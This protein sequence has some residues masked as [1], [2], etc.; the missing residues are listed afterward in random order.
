MLVIDRI[1]LAR[2]SLDAMNSAAAAGVLFAL[3]QFGTIG[4]AAITQVF[5]GQ[6]N[7]GG[8]KRLAGSAAWQMVWFGLLSALLAWPLAFYALPLLLASHHYEL[9]SPYLFWLFLFAPFFPAT[10]ALSSFFV[11]LGKVRYVVMVTLVSNLLN[12]LF[13]YLLIFGIEGYIPSMGTAGAAIA[14]G[15]AQFVQLVVFLAIFLRKR[16]RQEYGTHQWRYKSHLFWS[17]MAKGV[18]NSLAHMIEIAAHAITFR[19]AAEAGD[20]YLTLMT[21]GQTILI[22]I[23]FI[24]EGIS[25]A[26][27][28]LVANFIGAGQNHL[29]GRSRR[30]A[31]LLLFLLSLP[32]SVPMLFF[33]QLLITP[34]LADPESLQQFGPLLESSCRWLW[35]FF[36][37]DGIG[38][39]CNALL[40]AVGD[41]FFIM[42]GNAINTWLFCL[43]P[44][45]L[46]MVVFQGSPFYYWPIV[47]GYGATNALLYGWRYQSGRWK[48]L[49]PLLPASS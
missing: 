27:S 15:I 5:V 1:V 24:T 22:M 17:M 36:L 43:L 10:A 9:S 4:V 13:D 38:W 29:V 28:S 39:I 32:L 7:G 31:L 23:I 2:Y 37:I 40:T 20:G 8:E 25:K 34:F 47:C 30:S 12:G 6:Y 45:S 11:G 48:Q 44:L 14:T 46:L 21:V 49:Q 35:L 42:M 3:F 41:T 16:Y 26:L 19:L 18:P 33:P